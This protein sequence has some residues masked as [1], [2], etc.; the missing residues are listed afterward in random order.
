MRCLSDHSADTL[1]F[2][3]LSQTISILEERL[4]MSEDRVKLVEGSVQELVRRSA[5]ARCAGATVLRRAGRAGPVRAVS[6]T[7]EYSTVLHSTDVPC[8][9]RFLP[10]SGSVASASQGRRCSLPG[11][12]VVRAT[13]AAVPR[14][15]R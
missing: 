15:C 11:F 13:R 2:S 6:S 1:R 9:V 10:A 5:A 4:T 3:A 8:A 12:K 7:P 14:R